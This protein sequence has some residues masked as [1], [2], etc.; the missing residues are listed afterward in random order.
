MHEALC[1]FW[2]GCR[3]WK[4]YTYKIQSLPSRDLQLRIGSVMFGRKR[5]MQGHARE[6]SKARF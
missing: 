2:G 6:D 3:D 5:V 1:M 4:G